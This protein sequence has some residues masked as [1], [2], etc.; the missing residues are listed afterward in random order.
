M[1][2]VHFKWEFRPKQKHTPGRK[3]RHLHKHIHTCT[4]YLPQSAYVT[5]YSQFTIY[6]LN[7]LN[8]L[9]WCHWLLL[10]HTFSIQHEAV[11]IKLVKGNVESTHTQTKNHSEQPVLVLLHKAK[12]ETAQNVWGV[13]DRVPPENPGV[14]KALKW[15]SE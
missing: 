2:K 10:I 3:Q 13:V 12:Q 1:R 14:L 5:V 4:V 7:F 15:G 6:S 11:D 8:F 9:S